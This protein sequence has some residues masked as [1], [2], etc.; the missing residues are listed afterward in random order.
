MPDDLKI[1]LPTTPGHF[2]TPL[3]KP[4]VAIRL[5]TTDGGCTMRPLT[6]MIFV[7]LGENPKAAVSVC[8]VEALLVP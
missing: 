7:K 3:S 4:I 2:S 6:F 8:E 1:C 5:A